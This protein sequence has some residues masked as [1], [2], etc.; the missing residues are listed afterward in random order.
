MLSVSSPPSLHGVLKAKREA[1]VSSWTNMIEATVVPGFLPAVELVDHVPPFVDELIDVLGSDAPDRL[2][3]VGHGKGRL[4][5]GFDISQVVL[6]YGLLHGCVL[7][8]AEEQSIALTYRE[9]RV[10]AGWISIGITDAL[11][12]H[13][14]GEE[15]QP[16][17]YLSQRSGVGPPEN[18]TTVGST[19]S[20]PAGRR[21]P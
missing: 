3:T 6:E 13:L 18:P 21:S 17:H 4:H 14:E 16:R 8:I 10:L 19:P 11:A 15:A 5:P 7:R 20:F 2:A 1:L 9:Q 12:E